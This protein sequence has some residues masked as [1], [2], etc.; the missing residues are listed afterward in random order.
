[1]RK[2]IS[3]KALIVNIIT[4][5]ILIMAIYFAYQFYQQNNFNDFIRSVVV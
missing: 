2:S 5:V 4:F 1:M 3:A